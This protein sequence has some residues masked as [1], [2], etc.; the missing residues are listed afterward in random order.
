MR[1]FSA[2]LLK[3]RKRR[4]LVW[5]TL[6]LV[7]GPVLL[8]YSISAV[9]HAVDAERYDPAGGAE[10]FTNGADL[11]ALFGLIAAIIVGVGAGVGDLSAGVF[12][13]LVVTGRNR[14]ALFAIRIPGG[15]AF[16]LPI[17]AAAFGVV[18]AASFAFAGSGPTPDAGMIVRQAG[19]LL[20]ELGFAFITAV[21]VSSLMSSR[22]LAIGLLLGWHLAAA[23]LLLA[24][25][26]LDSFLPNSALD[27]LQPSLEGGPGISVATAFAILLV[28]TAAA[29]AAGAWRTATREA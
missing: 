24:T 23:P 3:L 1:L 12:R 29:V 19:F 13:E 28:W 18:V 6:A 2:E 8:A 20:L 22:G 15:L 26:K 27:R 25:G 14:L 11:L 4:G 5:S 21:G 16:L 17:A 9:L 10:N 7:L